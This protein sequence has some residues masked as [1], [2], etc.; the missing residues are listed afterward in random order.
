[1]ILATAASVCGVIHG[2]WQSRLPG[3]AA[4]E[5]GC[6]FSLSHKL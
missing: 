6:I 5:Q 2:L 3:A 1:M 4:N